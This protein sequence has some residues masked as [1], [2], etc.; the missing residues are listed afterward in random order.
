MAPDLT[1]SSDSTRHGAKAGT[2]AFTKSGSAPTTTLR[3][4][5]RAAPR[6]RWVAVGPRRLQDLAWQS[7]LDLRSA[8]ARGGLPADLSKLEL[9][10]T[11]MLVNPRTLRREAVAGVV[12]TGAASTG[13]HRPSCIPAD[14]SAV[15]SPLLCLG[16]MSRARLGTRS[17]KTW[18]PATRGRARSV[19][20]SN[21]EMSCYHAVCGSTIDGVTHLQVRHSARGPRSRSEES[22]TD[23]C[24]PVPRKDSQI[25][26][27]IC[28]HRGNPHSEVFFF[29]AFLLKLV[30][31]R[32]LF[33]AIAILASRV[34]HL[35]NSPST[36]KIIM[37][38]FC[39]FTLS[40]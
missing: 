6:F 32:I 28:R 23:S 11:P 29:F 39:F 13:G 19:H 14:A 7:K 27:A 40:F 5:A 12:A 16:Q 21:T 26:C 2:S 8:S 15:A 35:V 1:G 24:V 33:K 4:K 25:E 38:F 9:S 3:A 37:F 31:L 34:S 30:F 20:P 18:S 22:K 10:S 36:G 17:D